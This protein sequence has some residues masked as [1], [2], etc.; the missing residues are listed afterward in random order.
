MLHCLKQ[1]GW[2]R[3]VL[4][5]HRAWAAVAQPHGRLSRPAI[6]LRS[7]PSTNI[8]T[9]TIIEDGLHLWQAVIMANFVVV[10]NQSGASVIAA[11]ACLPEMHLGFSTAWHG[12]RSK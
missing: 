2:D 10:Q 7:W 8:I 3:S 11:D 4:A 1:A 9:Y 12:T 6:P 5:P